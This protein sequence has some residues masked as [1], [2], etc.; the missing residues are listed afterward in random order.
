[1]CINKEY[2]SLKEI[3]QEKNQDIIKFYVA[4]FMIVYPKIYSKK[5]K[6]WRTVYLFRDLRFVC[7]DFNA[8]EATLFVEINN[9][10]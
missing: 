6:G 9:D 7:H 2:K 10:V 3:L 8:P 5:P 1:M 4:Y